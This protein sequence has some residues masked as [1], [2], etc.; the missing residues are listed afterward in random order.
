VARAKKTP[1]LRESEGRG[2]K[3]KVTKS[4]LPVVKCGERGCKWSRAILP[5]QDASKLL[6][7]HYRDAKHV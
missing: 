1:R 2:V 3:H 7:D 6:T 5:G 4:R